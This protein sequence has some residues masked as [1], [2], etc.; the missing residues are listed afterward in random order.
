M[1]PRMGMS[2]ASAQWNILERVSWVFWV[3]FLLSSPVTSF[4]FFPFSI[5][6]DALVRPLA[7]YP[8]SVLLLIHLV[9]YLLSGK[10]LPQ[11]TLPLLIFVLVALSLLSLSLL[12]PSVPLRGQTP[13]SRASRGIISL[14]IGVSIYLVTVTISHDRRRLQAS[15][16]WLYV[17]L[18][19]T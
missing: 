17:A 15:L 12:Q 1:S 2:K 11:I 13:F 9:R 5:F 18:G 3:L 7:L 16:R 19:I 6:D 10:K 8:L 14:V 4:P